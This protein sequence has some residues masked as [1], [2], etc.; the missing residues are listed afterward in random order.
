MEVFFFFLL[1]PLVVFF[2][3]FRSRGW[4]A[5]LSYFLLE[6]WGSGAGKWEVLIFWLETW[7]GGVGKWKV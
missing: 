5:F 2:F 4:V 7:G 1:E 6:T 3:F